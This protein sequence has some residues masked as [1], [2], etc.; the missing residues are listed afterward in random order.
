M[1]HFRYVYLWYKN[2]YKFHGVYKVGVDAAGFIFPSHA[3]TH[4]ILSIANNL[5]DNKTNQLKDK[6]PQIIWLTISAGVIIF[7]AI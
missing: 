7:N 1:L 5:F 4:Y 2:E 3:K 6:T